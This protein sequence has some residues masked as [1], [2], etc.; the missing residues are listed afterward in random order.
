LD[1]LVIVRGQHGGGGRERGKRV[2]GHWPWEKALYDHG[3]LT[4]VVGLLPIGSGFA[5]W[6]K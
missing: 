5:T 3:S 2:S 6:R 4:V 1:P